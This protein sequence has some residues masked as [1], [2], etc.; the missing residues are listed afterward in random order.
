[1]KKKLLPIILVCCMLSVWLAA[2]AHADDIVASGNCGVTGRN[3][4]DVQWTL[5]SSGHLTISGHGAMSDS[6]PWN[7][8]RNMIIS[9]TVNEGVTSIGSLAFENLNRLTQATLPD[10]VLVI[11]NQ[12]FNGCSN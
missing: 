12:A 3:G 8:N 1:M 11:E 10:S 2:Y 9:V 6:H 5:D 7:S 4:S